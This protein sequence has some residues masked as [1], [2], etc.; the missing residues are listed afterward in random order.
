MP[1]IKLGIA[2]DYPVK[3][4]KKRILRDLIQNFYDAIGAENFEE[5]FH[6][7]FHLANSDQ[8]RYNVEMKTD[9]SSFSYE[10]LCHIGSS[11][12]T[13]CPGQFVGMY[14]EGFKICSLCLYRDYKCSIIMESRDWKINVCTYNEI[15]DGQPTT[16]LGFQLQARE[17]GILTK[18]SLTNLNENDCKY[19]QEAK[20]EFF[21]PSNP[22]FKEKLYE[23]KTITI[24]SRSAMSIPCS[25]NI[26]NFKGILYCNF[27]ARGRLQFP[28]IILVKIDMT[29]IDSRKRDVLLDHETK[30][31]LNDVLKSNTSPKASLIILESMKDFWNDMPNTIADV[32][33]WY[34]FICQLVRNIS[35]NKKYQKL[36]TM[37]YTKLFYI[38]RKGFD[39]DKN[40]IIDKTHIWAKNKSNINLVNPIFRMLGAKSLIKAYKKETKLEFVEPDQQ[41]QKRINVLLISLKYII[42]EFKILQLPQISIVDN[43]IINTPDFYFIKNKANEKRLGQK[44]KIKRITLTVDDIESHDFEVILFKTAFILLHSFAKIRSSVFNLHL[45]DLAASFIENTKILG[46]LKEEWNS[47]NEVSNNDIG[48]EGDFLSQTNYKLNQ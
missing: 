41:M 45:T 33:T 17:N 19:L 43:N 2:L 8:L 35:A 37:K 42:P 24:Y 12:K 4:E 9:K 13:N 6:L 1:I 44:Y 15:I 25:Q 36:F 23:D 31:L 11:T 7:D 5:C 34:Y 30:E 28:L 3:W 48:S 39:S 46:L 16:M 32:R 20:L 22:L 29:K 10:W 27:L 21:Y 47:R 40:Q 26:K 18:L 14:G 38:D